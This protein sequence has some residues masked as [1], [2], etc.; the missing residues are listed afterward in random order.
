[1]S[2]GF[3]KGP[4]RA[5]GDMAVPACTSSQGNACWGLSRSMPRI[6]F[7]A[8]KAGGSSLWEMPSKLAGSVLQLG[9]PWQP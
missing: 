1:M 8:K 4:L 7:P 2:Q 5:P 3:L 6:P 9:A